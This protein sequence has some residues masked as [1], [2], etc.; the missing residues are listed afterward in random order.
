MNHIKFYRTN[1]FVL[2]V[3]CSIV[4]SLQPAIGQK[5]TKQS[6]ECLISLWNHRRNLDPTPTIRELGFNLVWS[7]D[8]AYSGQSWEETHM[9]SLLQIPGVEYVFA[10]IERAAWGWTHEQSVAHAKWIAELSLEHSGILGLY[11]NDFY[12]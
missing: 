3:L 2:M 4:I 8:P 5:H 10:K 11:L 9:Y 7:H 12:D 6:D 1:L